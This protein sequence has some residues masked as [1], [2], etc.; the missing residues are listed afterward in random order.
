MRIQVGAHPAHAPS[1]KKWKRES[2]RER[3]KYI[4]EGATANLGGN[5]NLYPATFH[6]M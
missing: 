1:K 3:R 5:S 6:Y 4:Q 2:E